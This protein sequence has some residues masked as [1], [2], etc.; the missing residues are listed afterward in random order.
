LLQFAL[1]IEEVILNTGK[2]SEGNARSSKERKSETTIPRKHGG[3]KGK[4][5]Q[6]RSGGKSYILKGQDTPSCDF[7][8]KQGDTESV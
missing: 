6:K 3:G 7:C 2:D 4:A 1:N 5:I 8:G